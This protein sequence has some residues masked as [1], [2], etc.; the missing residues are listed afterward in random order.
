MV[1]R[2]PW[3]DAGLSSCITDHAETLL[4]TTR[5]LWSPGLSRKVMGASE[6]I[7]SLP[8]NAQNKH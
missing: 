5:G 2:V 6:I 4:C 3:Q 1:Q 7:P 8:M